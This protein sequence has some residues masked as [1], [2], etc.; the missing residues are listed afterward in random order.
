MREQHSLL[1]LVF[2]VKNKKHSNSNMQFD[3]GAL[4]LSTSSLRSVL[5]EECKVVV[6]IP[7][8][9][10]LLSAYCNLMRFAWAWIR[11]FID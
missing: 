1:D 4:S 10:H 3:T 11:A 9:F 5:K 6:W 7:R 8:R 2:M